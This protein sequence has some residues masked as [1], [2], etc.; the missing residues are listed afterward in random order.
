MA[1][2]R[3]GIRL[4]RHD[5]ILRAFAG[6]QVAISH[7]RGASS[8]RPGGCSRSTSSASGR[9]RSASSPRSAGSRRSS[10]RSSRSPPT[11]RWGIGPVAIAALVLS[12]I[13]NLFVPLAPAGAPLSPSRCLILAAAPRRFLADGLRHHRGR[14][15]PDAGRATGRSGACRRRSSSRR[16]S[17]SWSRRCGRRPG[18][19]RS[20]CARRCGSRRSSACSACG[21]CGSRR[22]AASS[23]LADR[24]STPR[25]SA[26]PSRR[27]SATARRWV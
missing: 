11:Q 15:A 8:A 2:I 22:S 12:T 20:A 6:S 5:P 27:S 19:V 24:R 23:E 3:E 4:V 1:E 7:A 13:G 25:P 16:G 14:R 21:S 10:A 9:R 18:R 17:P 26:R